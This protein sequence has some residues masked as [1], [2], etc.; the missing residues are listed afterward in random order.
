LTDR[1]DKIKAL[2][3]DDRGDTIIRQNAIRWLK[4]RKLYE[5]PRSNAIK[6]LPLMTKARL[7]KLKAY[8]D[9]EVMVD[10]KLICAGHCECKSSARRKGLDFYH[11]QLHH[12]GPHYDLEV[13]GRP[14]RIVIV[15]QEY[16]HGP[17][18]VDLDRR[19][20]M[21]GKSANDR[22]GARKL[23]MKGTTTLLR[24]VH[25]RVPREDREGEWL[26]L[27]SGPRLHLF[28]GFALVNYFLCTAVPPNTTNGKAT[29]QMLKNCAKH[30][31]KT[32][33]ILEPTLLIVQGHGVRRSLA[34]A[35]PSCPWNGRDN[36][37]NLDLAGIRAT[38]LTFYHPSAR[39]YCQWGRS[40]QSEY[41]NE[42]IIPTIA[43]ARAA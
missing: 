35:Y 19:H 37:E 42:I 5:M 6:S 36:Y 31:R 38:V 2:A 3:D 40:L 25:G 21:I 30:F 29:P 12:V 20:E 8:F 28:G 23:H 14:M 1:I 18:L 10:R 26:S 15:G 4:A 33:A 41:L 43:R 39:G 24:L 27:D 22:W 32:I 34:R 11:G 9:Q 17:S 16:G 7:E 13:G